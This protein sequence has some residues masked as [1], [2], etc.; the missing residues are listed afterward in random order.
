MNESPNDLERLNHPLATIIEDTN[1]DELPSNMV[2][3]DGHFSMM[4]FAMM[5]FKQSI[6]K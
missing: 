5:N 3:S 6:D 4:E 2:H 1:N